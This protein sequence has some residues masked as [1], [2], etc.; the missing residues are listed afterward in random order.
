MSRQ[1][2]VGLAA[3]LGLC[4]PAFAGVKAPAQDTDQLIAKYVEARGG[5]EAL[6]GVHALRMTGTLRP[7]G[8]DVQMKYRE[9]IA[10]PGSVRIDAT[11]QGLTVVQA[12]DGATGWQIQPF[13]GR[14]DPENLST[15]DV[16]SLAEEADF[17]GALVDYKA[18]GSTIENLGDIEIDGAPTHALRASL[19][20]GDQLTFYLDPDAYL[21]VRVLTRQVIRGADVFTQTDFGDY[22][23]TGGVYFPMEIASGPKGATQQQRITYDTIEV[24][25]VADAV[26][27]ARPTA[28][29]AAR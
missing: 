18:K 13:Q 22:E 28:P 19:K 16:K 6:K 10:R 12:Y 9:T 7:S 8:F 25:P 11:L 4:A 27:F 3:A 15:D 26:L 23:K 29:A 5:A 21:P 1:A 14:K 24:N 20:N 17:D 2:L